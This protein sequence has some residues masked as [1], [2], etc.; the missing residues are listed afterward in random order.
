MIS[1]V[2]NPSLLNKKSTFQQ[3]NTSSVNIDFGNEIS[4][5]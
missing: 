5:G 4:Q 2:V 3:I 1:E